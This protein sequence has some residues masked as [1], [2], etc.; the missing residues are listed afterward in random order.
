MIQIDIN[1]T[2]ENRFNRLLSIYKGDYNGLIDGFF[3]YKISELTKGIRNI[4][5]DLRF[6]E[7]KYGLS[8]RDFYE[9]FSNGE[10][11]HDND[12]LIWSGEY[13]AWMDFNNE[14][15]KLV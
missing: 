8:S 6:F 13:E 2:S 9:R 1:T 14:L 5:N 10:Y 11:G 3:N 15:E 7:K 4:E 12:Y